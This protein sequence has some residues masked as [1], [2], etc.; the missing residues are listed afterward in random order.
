MAAIGKLQLAAIWIFGFI[1][2]VG[3]W[4]TVGIFAND[5]PAKYLILPVAGIAAGIAFGGF[6]IRRMVGRLTKL[7]AKK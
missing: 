7:A 5:T 2:G 4:M 6:L 1:A 3:F